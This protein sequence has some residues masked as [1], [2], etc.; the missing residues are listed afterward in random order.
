LSKAGLIPCQAGRWFS[1]SPGDRVFYRDQRCLVASP[2]LPPRLTVSVTN[3]KNHCG[4]ISIPVC[5]L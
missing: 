5:F 4:T 3:V 1:R 2:A